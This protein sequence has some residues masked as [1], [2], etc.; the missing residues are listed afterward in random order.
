MFDKYKCLKPDAPAPSLRAANHTHPIPQLNTSMSRE[1]LF[2]ALTHRYALLFGDWVELAGGKTI[3]CTAVQRLLSDLDQWRTLCAKHGFQDAPDVLVHALFNSQVP[4]AQ[5]RARQSLIMHQRYFHMLLKVYRYKALEPRAEAKT[6]CLDPAIGTLSILHCVLTVWQR[7]PHKAHF[8]LAATLDWL[9][10]VSFDACLMLLGMCLE[11]PSPTF[12]QKHKPMLYTARSD[13]L[14]SGC[15]T[16]C[17]RRSDARCS[18]SIRRAR[19]REGAQCSRPAPTTSRS[20][21]GWSSG[22]EA[23]RQGDPG[24]RGPDESARRS[25]RAASVGLS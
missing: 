13:W 3:N 14:I 4:E 7:T 18:D 15:L 21:R 1:R 9:P 16:A 19:S 8:N 10:H 24:E 6:D 20:A 5:Y 17:F 2:Q 12:A 11:N 25:I 23:A 22:K